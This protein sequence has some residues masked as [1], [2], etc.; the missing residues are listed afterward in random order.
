M[1]FDTISNRLQAS[2]IENGLVSLSLTTCNV[3]EIVWEVVR[4]YQFLAHEK[5]QKLTFI[6][7]DR[8]TLF[9]DKRWLREVVDQLVSNAIKFT[10]IGKRIDV[11]LSVRE[12]RVVIEVQ[13]E[14]LGLSFADQ[15]H[16]FKRYT[17]LSA[18]PTGGECATGLGLSLTRRL[19]ELLGGSIWAYSEGPNKGSTFFVELAQD[20]SAAQAS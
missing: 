7:K 1:I 20:H 5:R 18:M 2:L 16:L 4:S 8:P 15:E 3:S 19:V 9:T 14:G 10:P 12:G 17:R 13:D 11:Q 6:V